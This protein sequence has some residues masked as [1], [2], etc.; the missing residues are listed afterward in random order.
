VLTKLLNKFADW[1][2][3]RSVH[4][5]ATSEA[6]SDL[7]VRGYVI[8]DLFTDEPYLTRVVFPRVPLLGFRPLLHKFH[9]PDGERTLH[10]HPWT[11]ALSIILSGSYTEERLYPDGVTRT[12]S[13][14]WFNYLTSR[15]Y[16]RVVEL[17]GEVWTLFV[18]GRRVQN[19]GF[20]ENGQFI[21][22][23]EYIS[24]K[25]KEYRSLKML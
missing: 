3:N 16:H 11:S 22:F 23:D 7:R 15:D 21:R 6:E 2:V 13:I 19:W 10:N 5:P 20:L 4:E 24:R 12:R 8:R 18:T 9:R 25:R 17:H 1:A 14:S